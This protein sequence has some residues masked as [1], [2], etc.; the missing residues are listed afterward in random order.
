M[1]RLLS[2]ARLT[3]HDT[4]FLCQKVFDACDICAQSGVPLPKKKISVTHVNEAF[5]QSVQTDF[6]VV[7]V[8][9][10]KQYVLNIVCMGTGYEERSAVANRSAQTMIAKL[11]C[12]WLYHPGSLSYFSSDPEFCNK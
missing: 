4:K 2:D 6:L 9:K 11:E 3:R 7:Y 10:V 1:F 8:G 12:E 5:N